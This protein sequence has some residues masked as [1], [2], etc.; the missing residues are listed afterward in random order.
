MKP[1]VLLGKAPVPGGGEVTLHQRD[2]EVVLRVDGAELMSTRRHSSE[3]ALAELGCLA[4]SARR[5]RS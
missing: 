2:R 5:P 3:D 4:T 1:W